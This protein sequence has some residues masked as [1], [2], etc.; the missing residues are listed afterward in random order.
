MSTLENIID[1]AEQIQDSLH[2]STLRVAVDVLEDMAERAAYE[3]PSNMTAE[4]VAML[5]TL[6]AVLVA[7]NDTHTPPLVSLARRL[8]RE[9]RPYMDVSDMRVWRTSICSVFDGAIGS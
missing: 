9:V 5:H 7:A 4:V 8:R 2:Y 1:N 6:R 3:L